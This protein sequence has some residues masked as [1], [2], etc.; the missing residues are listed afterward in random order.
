M[1]SFAE[2]RDE[3]ARIYNED[4]AKAY[5]LHHVNQVQHALQSAALAE[6][7]GLSSAMVIAC[8][9]H[10]IGHMVHELGES[11]AARGIDDLHEALGA[12]WAAERFGTAVSEPIRLHVAAKRYLCTVEPDYA[13]RLA[14]D[15]TRSLSLQGGQMT[16]EET[17]AFAAESFAQ[18]AVALRRIDECAKDPHARTPS[19][20][21][22]L[23]RHLAGALTTV[24]AV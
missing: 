17:S 20:D 22:L 24:P 4:G 12:Q 7:Q 14:R 11:P 15:S 18:D 21:A 13:A 3:I 5:G 9:L 19:L 8:L 10:D 23:D 16:A 1:A 6:Q 2:L